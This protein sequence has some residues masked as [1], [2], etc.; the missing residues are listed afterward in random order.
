MEDIKIIRPLKFKMHVCVLCETL[1]YDE[2]FP[3][4]FDRKF[5]EYLSCRK[6]LKASTINDPWLD[7][8]YD[9]NEDIRHLSDIE[10]KYSEDEEFFSDNDSDGN[11]SS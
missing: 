2:L 1:K 4:Y 3:S 9:Y 6:C 11:Y 7:Y 5:K 8:E 10:D